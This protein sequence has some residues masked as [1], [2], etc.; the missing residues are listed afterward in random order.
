MTKVI[1][2]KDNYKSSKSKLK[3]PPTNRELI[4]IVNSIQ[5]I[6]SEDDIKVYLKWTSPKIMTINCKHKIVRTS[7]SIIRRKYYTKGKVIELFICKDRV[8]N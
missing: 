7:R 8:I 1:T 2:N 6:F 3:W 4:D 5:N